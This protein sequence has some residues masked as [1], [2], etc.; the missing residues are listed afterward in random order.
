MKLTLRPEDPPAFKWLTLGAIIGLA[1]FCYNLGYHRAEEDIYTYLKRYTDN[2]FF[3]RD[4]YAL[5]KHVE[6]WTYPG[7]MNRD[8]NR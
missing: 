1:C 7:S 3:Q 6:E 2:T 4:L 8:V 5:L